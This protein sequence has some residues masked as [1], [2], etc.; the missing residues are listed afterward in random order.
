MA[1]I[2]QSAADVWALFQESDRWMKE[3]FAR[4]EAQRVKYLAEAE[5]KRVKDLAE[6]E[7]KRE[8]AETQRVKD[9]EEAEAKRVKD[10]EEAEAKAEAQR[11]KDR[12]EFDKKMQDIFRDMNRTVSQLGQRVGNIVEDM[13]EH[14]LTAK[15][16][17]LGLEVLHVKR[18]E[19]FVISGTEISGE[20]DYLVICKGKLIVVE[21]KTNLKK[22]DVSNT[23]KSLRH[24]RR[25]LDVEKAFSGRTVLG[26]MYG[27]TYTET[28][29]A[30]ALE[31][32]LYFIEPSGENIIVT[33][34]ED[35]EKEW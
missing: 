34:P 19:K 30:F 8:K 15:F 26:A 7:A 27:V 14:G 28:A 21:C 20:I 24:Y 35:G 25:Y 29:K 11:V 32:G 12:A 16:R 31:N 5:A 3:M 6:A 22:S 1:E 9:R 33:V 2:A 18:N 10:R 23:L 13:L 4:Q 17:A